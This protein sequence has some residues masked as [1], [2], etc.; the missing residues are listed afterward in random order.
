MSKNVFVGVGFSKDDDSFKAGKEAAEVALK[1]CGNK[2]VISFVFYVGKYDAY[3][4]NDGIKSILDGT[5]FVGGSTDAVAYEDQVVNKGVLVVSMYSNYLHVGVASADN[6]SSDPYG[7]SKK[8]MMEALKKLTMDKYLDSYLMFSRMKTGNVQGLVKIPSFFVFLFSR[9]FRLP[10]MGE[11][12]K[13]I[14]GVADV[15]GLHIPIYGGSFGVPLQDVFSGQKYDIYTLHSGKVMKDGLIAVFASCGLIYGS[16]IA[17][18]CK[19]TEDMGFISGCL[20][21]GYV[22]SEISHK[23]S[24]EWYSEMIDKDKDDFMKNLMMYTQQ[25]PLGLPDNYGNFV[26]RAGG[27]PFEDK[28]AYVTPFIKGLPV[29]IMDGDQKNLLE[30]ADE[31]YNDITNYTNEDSAPA[32]CF[33][34]LCGSRRVVLKDKMQTELKSLKKSFKGAPVVGF[35]SFGEIGSKPGLPPNF[36]HLSNSVFV[37]YDKL[38][39]QLK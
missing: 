39:N 34:V 20:N 27:V 17:H 25:Y 38:L 11:E 3:K 18:G 16:S 21:D 19:P 35:F 2:P 15:V 12:T 6:I 10:S 29:F 1:K 31:I 30:A 37:I 4:L 8:N 13:I 33:S 36:Q 7:V 23:N 24:I 22:V 14:K 28:L 5:E 32:V 9:G 26:I